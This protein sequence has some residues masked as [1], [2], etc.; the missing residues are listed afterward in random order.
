MPAG[1]A[2]RGSTSAAIARERIAV[3]ATGTVQQFLL[4]GHWCASWSEPKLSFRLNASGRAPCGEPLLIHSASLRLTAEQ[5]GAE[6]QLLH[7]IAS[8]RDLALLDCRV[9]DGDIAAWQRRLLP[10][11]PCL[12]KLNVAGTM[13]A[14]ARL[15]FDPLECRINEAHLIARDF[16]LPGPLHIDEP[17]V[18]LRS[19]GIWRPTG[20]L[21]LRNL[22][23]RIG[24][25]HHFGGASNSHHSL[26]GWASQ[27]VPRSRAS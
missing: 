3:Q 7:P 22:D 8:V 25:G 18:E 27:V 16:Q 6:V 1:R 20:T 4:A 10:C 17:T 15:T 11:L 5:A 24:R 13:N 9:S 19:Q 21:E 23:L 12:G 14:T 26:P 2:R